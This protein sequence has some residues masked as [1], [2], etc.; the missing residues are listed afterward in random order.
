MVLDSELFVNH[1]GRDKNDALRAILDDLLHHHRPTAF[2]V[3]QK[4]EVPVHSLFHR[5]PAQMAPLHKLPIL[6]PL[7]TEHLDIDCGPLVQKAPTD[8]L[9]D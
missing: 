4:K 8:S 9:R 7:S 6:H 2:V 1:I 3:S 5:I